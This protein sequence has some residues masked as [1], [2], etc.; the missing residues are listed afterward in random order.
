[1]ADSLGLRFE[2]VNGDVGELMKMTRSLINYLDSPGVVP[3]E[4]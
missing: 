2:E 3:T 4:D 1:M